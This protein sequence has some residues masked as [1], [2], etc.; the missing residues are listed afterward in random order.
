MQFRV[1][2]PL[3]VV[4]DAGSPVPLGGM[5]QRSVLGILL[6]SANR[7]VSVDRLVDEIWPEDR[8]ERPASTLQV[9]VHN[10]RKLLEPDRAAGATPQVLTTQAPGYCLRSSPADLD[11]LRFEELLDAARGAKEPER[12]ADLLRE[13]LELWRGPALADLAYETWAV[14]DATRL[15]ELRLG[16][17]EDR[18]DAELE[19][20][21]HAESIAELETMVSEQPMRE[22]RHAQLMLA[23]YR[24]GR[25][26]EALQAFQRARDVL[27]EELGIDPGPALRRLEQEILEQDPALDLVA[28]TEGVRRAA[29]AGAPPALPVDRTTLVGRTGE[30]DGIAALLH[31]NRLVTVT[32]AAGSGKTRVALEVAHAVA[33]TFADGVAF[34][35]LTA[36]TNPDD[37]SAA[38][39]AALA[40]GDTAADEGIAAATDRRVLLVLDN[41]EHVID[42]CVP[43]VEDLLTRAPSI[44]VL[45]TSQR[46]LGIEGE[47]AWPLEPLG[48]PP[49]EAASDPETMLKFDA[50]RLFVYRAR[51]AQPDFELTV[52]NAPAVQ[53]IVQRLDGLPLAIALAASRVKALGPVDLAS[54]LDDRFRILTAPSTPADARHQTLRAA[55][56]WSFELLEG[57][58]QEA[59]LRLSVFAGPFGLDAATA[60]GRVD[61]GS[62]MVHV[63][64]GL[65]DRSL[66]SVEREQAATRYRLLETIQMYAR[67]QLLGSALAPETRERHGEWYVQFVE[68][69]ETH[70]QGTDA[71]LWVSQLERE[72]DN[73][74]AALE[75]SLDTGNA[76][77]ALRIAGSM[78]AFWLRRGYLR[79]GRSWLQRS[80]D[81]GMPAPTRARARALLA[82]AALTLEVGNSRAARALAEESRDVFQSLG[83][84]RGA[85]YA[86]CMLGAVARQLGDTAAARTLA[87]GAL[88]EFRALDDAA[89]TAAVLRDLGLLEML[90]GDLDLARQLL[91]EGLDAIDAVRTPASGGRMLDAAL[92][93][94][95]RSQ[96]LADLGRVAGLSGDHARAT[97]LVSESIAVAAATGNRL[98]VAQGARAL[99][100]IAAES[101]EPETAAVLQAAAARVH[102]DE[103]DPR[104]TLDDDLRLRAALGTRLGSDALTA[105]TQR[106]RALSLDQVVRLAQR[107]ATGVSMPA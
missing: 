87:E 15:E 6:L 42:A 22:R 29:R 73:V 16:A 23:L 92:A 43:L 104:S 95:G 107:F 41:C 53:E 76:D 47:Q 69:A 2:G 75:W 82:A 74:R 17:A 94:R 35:D 67:E 99:A 60:V 25:Q 36:V 24:C 50:V 98:G 1:L 3:E 106:G 85:T 79:D 86:V 46:S 59:L 66:V 68:E 33:P 31:H 21:A 63:L 88:E 38:V 100:L 70:L 7:V 65:V 4:D 48:V 62:D 102:T 32:G 93:P 61:D 14:A 40:S 78:G 83:D 9:Y 30:L 77:R 8:P 57:H 90:D 55:I 96:M 18:I 52:E 12:V 28:T 91:E 26:A 103:T 49:T 64:F 89:G 105:A 56:G 71:D 20:G 84:A 58:D 27:V 10:L 81:V 45:A 72:H 13:A 11:A 97:S 51:S 44:R 37:V 80:L 19:L 101:G 34:A 5:K 39:S 54:R